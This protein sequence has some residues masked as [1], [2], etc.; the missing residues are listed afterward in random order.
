MPEM[1]QNTNQDRNSGVRTKAEYFA[2]VT[3]ALCMR[4][5]L[6][7]KVV[8]AHRGA[9]YVSLGMRL[10][11]SLQLDNALK[12]AEPLAL[13]CHVP[14][15]L[16]HRLEGHVVYQ[17]QLPEEYWIYYT[18]EPGQGLVLGYGDRAKPV[19]HDLQPPHTLVGGTSGSGKTE[20]IKAL[21]ASLIEAHSPEQLQLVL[22]DPHN[23]FVEFDNNQWLAGPV[24]RTQMDIE[25]ALTWVSQQLIQ[26]REKNI[27][28][29]KRIVVIMD[30]ADSDVVLK[31]PGNLDIVASLAKESRKFMFNLIIGMQKATHK[32]MPDILDNLV[33]RYIGKV[34]DA[35]ISAR[36]TGWADLGCH[37]LTGNG[38]FI[39]VSGAVAERFQVAR[40]PE[41][42]VN[43]LNRVELPAWN[44]MS[45][46][47]AMTGLENTEAEEDILLAGPA[48]VGRPANELNM[49]LLAR[50]LRY[51]PEYFSPQT[52]REKL[53][54]IL[55]RAVSKDLHFMHK[56][57][58]RELQNELDA[59]D[60]FLDE[61][62]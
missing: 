26:R 60:L 48:Q 7:G 37:K 53:S 41:Q 36:L 6:G 28:D 12:L 20:T 2:K 58:A 50:Y 22:I 1:N 8:F 35:A 24:A 23:D 40:V 42:F 51:G 5:K 55:G 14:G 32:K 39:H 10:S 62:M 16:A 3:Q 31:Q 9:R 47:E 33:N 38:D 49:K 56:K 30:E 29:E 57:A 19:A 17:F 25:L 59:L 21:I 43:T 13:A 52:A 61:D 54:P 44:G 45:V 27:R 15:V 4:R 11:D 34:S 46:I 18:R